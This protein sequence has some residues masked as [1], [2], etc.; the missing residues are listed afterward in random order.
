MA[1]D[2]S[3][4]AVA[5]W[6]D[7]LPRECCGLTSQST[8]CL[9]VFAVPQARPLASFLFVLSARLRAATNQ[10]VA[11]SSPAGRANSLP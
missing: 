3:V 8:Y 10:E 11:G 1:T 9:A 2:G 6:C 7:C 4:M 5:A